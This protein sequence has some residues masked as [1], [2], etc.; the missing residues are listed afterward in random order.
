MMSLFKTEDYSRPEP[1][2]TVYG[3][4]RKLF[5]LKKEKRRN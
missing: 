1:V 2:K 5:E 3:S 4:I